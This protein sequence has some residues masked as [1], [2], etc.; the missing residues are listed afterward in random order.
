L[1]IYETI[2]RVVAA[3]RR[4]GNPRNSEGD[5]LVVGPGQYVLTYTEFLDDDHDFA[6]ARIVARS[7]T[8]GGATWSEPVLWRENPEG[9][10]AMCPSLLARGESWWLLYLRK[11]GFDDCSGWLA[12]S[13]DRGRT[14][15]ADDRRVTARPGYWVI[16][17]AR[18]VRLAGGRL[19]TAG[20]HTPVYRRD[21]SFTARVLVSDDDGR[22]WREAGEVTVPDRWGA[23]EPD[24]AELRDG[25]IVMAVR[26][27]LGSPWITRSTDGGESWEPPWPSGLPS[28]NSPCT[29]APT[30]DGDLLLVYNHSPE[31]RTPLSLARSGDGG[32]S[33]DTLG[34]LED[35]PDSRY[36]YAS[37]ADEG[38]DLLLTYYRSPAG[39]P[40]G[41]SEIVF[42][43]LRLAGG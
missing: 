39:P 28:P 10:N 34:D 36:G 8:D 29:L 4:P 3:P 13:G 9:I 11:N 5:L 43:R 31:I 25:S 20:S 21:C 22:R 12:T 1:E 18:L 38:D 27:A 42:R 2:D 7:T 41:S 24:L 37:V 33:W 6:R 35:D 14:W 19:V 26:T 23:W 15:E 40:P 30:G 17:N 16:E 32:L